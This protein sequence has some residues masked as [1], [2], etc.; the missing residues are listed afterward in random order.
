MC[1]DMV[2]NK[3]GTPRWLW[4]SVASVVQE[5]MASTSQSEQQEDEEKA[6]LRH[7][8]QQLEEAAAR[9]EWESGNLAS[10]SHATDEERL[11]VIF[12]VKTGTVCNKAM[13]SSA[14]SAAVL[15]VKLRQSCTRRQPA[16]CR[17]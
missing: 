12:C 13:H 14:L 11:E 2:W 8:I 6:A 4:L 1:H 16:C 9:A 3:D 15:D 10:S 7:H 17:T 5:R